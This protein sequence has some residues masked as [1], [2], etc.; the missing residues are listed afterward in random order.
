MKN[1]SIK[2]IAINLTKD[3]QEMAKYFISDYYTKLLLNIAISFLNYKKDCVRV[4]M[5]KNDNKVA[6]TDGNVINISYNNDITNMFYDSRLKDL[7]LKGLLAHETAHILYTNFKILKELMTSL[8]KGKLYCESEITHKNKDK[9]VEMLNKNRIVKEAIMRTVKYI[10]NVFEDAYIEARLM[11]EFPHT[12]AVKGIRLN[13]SKYATTVDLSDSES[14]YET[15]INYLYF[16]LSA[17]KTT[18][19]SC[20]DE[21]KDCINNCVEIC[22]KYVF[23]NNPKQ[24]TIG[25]IL[26]LLEMWDF[27][28]E[29]LLAS[30]PMI[31]DDELNDIDDLLELLS[32]LLNN[33]NTLETSE[34]S[35]SNSEGLANNDSTEETSVD[36][37]EFRNEFCNDTADTSNESQNDSS[38]DNSENERASDE[39]ITVNGENNSNDNSQPI[40]FKDNIDFDLEIKKY[41]KDKVDEMTDDLVANDLAVASKYCDL[42]KIHNGIKIKIIDVPQYS[43]SQYNYD[44]ALQQYNILSNTK[45]MS[46]KIESIIKA[47]SYDTT[48]KNRQTGKKICTTSLYRPDKKFFINKQVE[49]TISPLAVTLLVDLSG[50]MEGSRLHYAKLG[51]IQLL[52]FCNRINVPISVYGHDSSGNT[53]NIYNFFNFNSSKSK[54]YSLM[55]MKAGKGNRDG[56]AI[57]FCCEQLDKREEKKMFVII[58]DGQPAASGYVGFKAEN[59]I[60][61]IMKEYQKKGFIFVSASIGS[62]REN[63]RRIYGEKNVIDITDLSVLPKTLVKVI[64]NQIMY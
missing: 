57:R 39:N 33:M 9:M 56:A 40:D 28:V 49:E 19:P 14:N 24:R 35:N 16:Y 36:I 34:E 48:F 60:H 38:E 1:N 52:E 26:V 61:S 23:S 46:R 37:D 43:S 25:S 15:I 32:E 22:K 62:D 2:R 8:S 5:K 3:E 58:S 63:I 45:K 41:A 20:T 55:N 7:S 64:K 31:D 17:Q 30:C 6:Y 51:A 12:T 47:Q 13:N 27:F 21:V 4:V 11:K 59:D 10:N 18:I 29:D 44:K 53:V 50:S 54:K 42:G